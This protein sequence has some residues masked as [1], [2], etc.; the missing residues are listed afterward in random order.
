MKLFFGIYIWYECYVYIY[1]YF[2][3]NI[4]NSNNNKV[5]KVF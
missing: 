5:N 2:I 3:Y 1:I 4:G